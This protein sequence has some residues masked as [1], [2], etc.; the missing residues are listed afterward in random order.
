MP[1]SAAFQAT[2][3]RSRPER[4]GYFVRGGYELDHGNRPSVTRWEIT[5]PSSPAGDIRTGHFDAEQCRGRGG[6]PSGHRGTTTPVSG[7]QASVAT[8]RLAESAGR[9][10]AA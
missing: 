9:V 10:T 8:A 6:G 5:A 2:P 1:T 4:R 3:L 7:G